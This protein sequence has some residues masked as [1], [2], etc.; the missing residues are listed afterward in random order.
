MVDLLIAFRREGAA[1]GSAGSARSVLLVTMGT[2]V[3][4]AVSGC[5]TRGGPGGP[6]PAGEPS[7][8]F[9]G[10]SA[11]ADSAP[12]PARIAS[13]R[14]VDAGRAERRDG[15][16]EGAAS[17]LERAVRIDP[18]NGRAYLELALVRADQDRRDEALG[19]V[20]RALDLLPPTGEIRDRAEALRDRLGG[21][22]G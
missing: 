19:L 5:A 4:L 11:A 6:G 22:G 3:V 16:L 18:S 20:E 21:R 1:P 12:S 15:H 10:D 7:A 17:L 13:N 14:L 8:G 9:A 2:V